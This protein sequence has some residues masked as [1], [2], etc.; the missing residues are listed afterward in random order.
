MTQNLSMLIA[1]V[2]SGEPGA[3]EVLKD[4]LLEAGAPEHAAV[5]FIS[6]VGMG[7]E[8]TDPYFGAEME[9]AMR[10]PTPASAR[11]PSPLLSDIVRPFCY[12]DTVPVAPAG[13]TYAFRDYNRRDGQQKSN[14]EAN[15][16]QPKRLPSYCSMQLR[17]VS[18][19][20][21]AGVEGMLWLDVN[22]RPVLQLP[23]SELR[24]RDRFGYP[25]L[26]DFND[27]D[28]IR[29]WFD[30]EP[31]SAEGFVKLKLHGLL[32]EPLGR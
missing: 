32:K 15:F 29:A 18:V 17:R 4:L 19:D 13:R 26:C 12:Y 22:R 11:G 6:A 21:P 10:G 16:T 25:V 24:L 14:T 28:D 8:L 20:V 9:R 5:S 31:T 3:I 27:R 23:L 1:R 30:F 7:P 2:V